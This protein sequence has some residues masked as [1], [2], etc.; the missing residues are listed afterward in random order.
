DYNQSVHEL[1]TARE[2]VRA[3]E[4]TNNSLLTAKTNEV[5]RLLTVIS[6]LVLPLTFIASVFGMNALLPLGDHPK[7]FW[8]ILASMVI[9]MAMMYFYFK[10]KRWV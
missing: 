2:T 1:E 10:R 9:A 5:V 8:F 3:L 7:D 6:T 4:E